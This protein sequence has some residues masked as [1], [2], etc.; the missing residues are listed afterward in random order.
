MNGDGEKFIAF[1]EQLPARNQLHKSM[2]KI[3]LSWRQGELYIVIITNADNSRVFWHL[4]ILRMYDFDRA[5]LRSIHSLS[6]G[7]LLFGF[8]SFVAE[9]QLS[10]I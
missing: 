9:L 8:F 10:Y 2:I 7:Y 3:K 4:R 5:K 1:P 6:A